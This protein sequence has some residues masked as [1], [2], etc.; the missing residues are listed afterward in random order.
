[1]KLIR[2]AQDGGGGDKIIIRLRTD[3][4]TGQFEVKVLGHTGSA[5]CSDGLD[6]DI[7]Q[8]LL[9]AEIPGFGNMATVTGSGKTSE[10]IDAV[11]KPSTGHKVKPN[12]TEEEDDFLETPG[13]ERKMDLGFGV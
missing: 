6:D 4:K 7:L 3:K 13:K 2:V 11:Q 5:S 12:S 10:G 9:E 1:M 8:D